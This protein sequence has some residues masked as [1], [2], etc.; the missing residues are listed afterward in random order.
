MS[1]STTINVIEE[2]LSNL[3]EVVKDVYL[4]KKEFILPASTEINGEEYGEGY[5][6]EEGWVILADAE[7]EII[8]D[9]EYRFEEA[10]PEIVAAIKEALQ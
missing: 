6:V 5:I 4:V 2:N 1:D 3:N 7:T 9:Y 8:D 10:Y